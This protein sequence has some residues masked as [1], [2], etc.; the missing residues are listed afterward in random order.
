MDIG[1]QRFFN[2][3]EALQKKGL[4][5]L[6]FINDKLMTLSD[7][8]KKLA[9][10][11]KDSSKFSGIQGSIIGKAFLEAF[12]SNIS[13]QHEIQYIFIIKPTFSKYTKMDEV[14]RRLLKV[15]IPS[16]LR[17]DELCNLIE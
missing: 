2:K 6:G 10:M 15:S 16:N 8:K 12:Q 9:T 1:V 11:A 7:Y 5:G 3:I 14:Y 13:I 17:W 4:L